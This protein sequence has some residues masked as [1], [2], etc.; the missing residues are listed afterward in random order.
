MPDREVYPSAPLRLVTAE[1]RFP[2]SAR[3]S[4]RD[5]LGASAEVLGDAYPVIEPAEQTVQLSLGADP[6][7]PK[8][9]AEGYR[10]LTRERTV[11]V[12]VTPT[13]L[14]VETT[15]YKHWEDFRDTHVRRSLE[16]IGGTLRAIVGLQR[17]GLRYIDE[18][19]TPGAGSLA[20]RWAPYITSDL[21]APTQL[22][23][24]LNVD[25][26]QGLVHL[27]DGEHHQVALRFGALEGYTV[28]D[29]GPLRVP[30]PTIEGPYFLIDIDSFWSASTV[31]DVFD[32]EAAIAVTDKL[33]DPVGA[34]F[35]RC[36]T[37]KL[38]EDVL[39]RPR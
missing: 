20:E 24:G 23:G 15:T 35:E 1:F 36:I 21:L 33:H 19:R 17:V 39:R 28:G 10:L 26:I 16:A 18:I 8:V 38:R 31:I 4:E 34:I 29:D 3:L 7:P 25:A 37:E 11:A 13:R 30:T 9:S 5:L 27:G 12:T 14:A 2:L 32:L 6:R 22:A